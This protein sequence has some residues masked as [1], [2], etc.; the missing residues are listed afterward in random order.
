MKNVLVVC[1]APRDVRELSLDHVK[2]GYNLIFHTYDNSLLERIICK[3][4]GWMTEVFDPAAV[5]DEMLSICEREKIDGIVTSEDYPGSI[6]AS[7]I[8]QQAGL[9]TPLPEQVLLFQHKYYSRLAQL[10]YVPEATP[11]FMLAN[12]EQFN[13]LL[14]D[15]PF[16]VFIKPVKSYFSVFANS[17]NNSD[18]LKHLIKTSVLP[19]EFLHQFNWF[20]RN[21]TPY[22]L[23]ANYLLVENSLQGIQVTFEG[24]VHKGTMVPIGIV[25]SVMFPGTICFKRFEYPSSLPAAV[26]A[27]MADIATRLMQGVGFD[28]GFFNIEF[29]YNPETE[30]IHIIEVNPRMVSQFADLI[31]KVDGVNTYAY[32]LALATGQ[33]LNVP[34]RNG[35]HGMA[36]CFVLRTF[37]D[38]KVVKVPTQDQL[39][40]VYEFFLDARI[41]LYV[42]EG[43]TLSDA[44]QDGKSFRYGLVHLGGRDRKDLFEKFERC[45]QLLAFQFTPVD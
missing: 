19:P 31:E 23:D 3:G 34:K 39:D 24:F 33:K 32:L 43:D 20:V 35:K 25:D 28:N 44:F 21:Y 7:I 18:E 8:A 11:N 17:A 10:K 16:P 1:P 6:F 30:T 22:D 37:E 40:R 12:S 4:I 14:F 41:Q 13:S 9:P 15:L 38:K 29:M 27:R 26:Q 36:A 5:I 45:K 2:S 42:K